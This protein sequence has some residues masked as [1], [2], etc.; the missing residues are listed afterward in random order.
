M[1]IVSWN[2]AGYKAILQKGF[3]EYLAAEDPDIICLQETKISPK[4]AQTPAGYH[5]YFY[6]STSK[7]GYSGTAYLTIT[8]LTLIL[9]PVFYL[10]WNPLMLLMGWGL[11][12]MTMKVE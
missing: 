8:I 9:Y 4:A 5:G 7:A 1:K 11:Q 6:E 10:K 12:S 3:K 2:V